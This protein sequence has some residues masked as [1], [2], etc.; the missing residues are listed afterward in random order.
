MVTRVGYCP[1]IEKNY[2]TTNTALNYYGW[3]D[4][5]FFEIEKLNT[6]EDSKS[7]YKK[8]PA[9]IK[10]IA[11]TFVIKNSVDI[12]LS[13][14]SVNKVLNSNLPHEAHNSFVRVHWGDFDLN[15]GLPI[16]ALSNSYV[17]VADKPVYIE[18][19]PPFNHI[20]PSIRIIPG[21]FNIFSWQRPVVTTFEM[22][23]DRVT[24][25]RGEPLAYIRFRSEDLKDN[26][27]LEKI[28]RT[29]ELEHRVNSCLTLKH[30]LPNLSWKLHNTIKGIFPKKWLK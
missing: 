16:V 3:A 4:L 18:V 21:S 14:D 11:D 17:F 25:K 22:L 26:F 1:W 7:K 29:N 8:C 23:S 15:E 19:I 13:W 9:F 5:A 2:E 10:Y 20:I 24:I 28:S 30:Y 12:E 6:W 27:L